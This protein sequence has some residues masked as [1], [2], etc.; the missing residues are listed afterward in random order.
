[1]PPRVVRAF[2]PLDSMSSDH[3]TKTKE[4][5]R[6]CAL[7]KTGYLIVTEGMYRSEGGV[8]RGAD[9]GEPECEGFVLVSAGRVWVEKNPGM[10]RGL[11]SRCRHR[12]AEQGRVN[13]AQADPGGSEGGG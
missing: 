3:K 9:G 7:I 12:S 4:L 1:M 10:H 11:E 5:K 13:L 2:F 6:L 8:W